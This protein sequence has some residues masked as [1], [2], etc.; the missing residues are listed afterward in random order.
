MVYLSNIK[1]IGLIGVDQGGPYASSIQNNLSKELLS[2][3]YSQSINNPT[4]NHRYDPLT[5]TIQINNID[6]TA[7]GGRS[8]FLDTLSFLYKKG[9]LNEVSFN[10]YHNSKR[11]EEILSDS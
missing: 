1:C 5:S 2:P 10:H 11:L 9:Y 4:P 3:K 7:Q 6:L 8:A